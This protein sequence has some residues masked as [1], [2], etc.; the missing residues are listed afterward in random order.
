MI[1]QDQTLKNVSVIITCDNNPA[2][3]ERATHCGANAYLKKPFHSDHLTEKVTALLSIPR[4][5]SYRVLLKAS[6]NGAQ[7]NDFFYC[8]SRDISVAGIMIETERIVNKGDMLSLLF[9][10]PGHGQISAEGEVMRI[11]NRGTVPGYGI[12]FLHLSHTNRE[13]IKAFIA[14]RSGQK[15]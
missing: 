9:V 3:I 8:S 1:R 13:A 10:L 4:R 11:D 12:R 14:D 2:S 7:E 6:V 5:Q 15:P